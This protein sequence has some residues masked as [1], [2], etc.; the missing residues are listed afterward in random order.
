MDDSGDGIQEPLL[1][2]S[3]TT[4]FAPVLVAGG[5]GGGDTDN[6]P[7]VSL[8]NPAAGATVS[9][10]VNVTADASDDNSVSQV[11]FFIDGFSI[12]WDTDGS[13]GYSASWD[14]TADAD[15]GHT[16]EAAVTDS[17]GQTASDSISVTVDN[18]GGTTYPIDLSVTAYKVRG[19]QQADLS[20]SGATS[21][22]VDVFRD[23]GLAATTANDGA[24]T[25]ITGQNGG[26]SAVYQVCEAG[27]T[28]CSAEVTAT[29]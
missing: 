4:L 17:A 8:T 26:G 23:G 25:D 6:P 7:S 15:G 14:T 24:Y 16:V 11:E 28:T 13:D 2:V 22:N 5:G 18:S 10:T 12:G 21:T 20:W 3:S 19:R 27:T 9:G 1:D 29:W